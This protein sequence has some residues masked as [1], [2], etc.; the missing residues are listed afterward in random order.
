[1]TYIASLSFFGFVM[2]PESI[3]I[4]PNHILAI[5]EWPAFPVYM[6]FRYCLGL[7]TFTID[8]LMDLYVLY[9]S[10]WFFSEK[11]NNSTRLTKYNLHLMNSSMTS[12]LLL[13]SNMLILI[14]LSGYYWCLRICNIWHCKP[15]PWSLLASSYLLFSHNCISL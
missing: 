5:T 7:L 6:I 15:A 4:D 14:F 12:H 8:L 13:F 11:I 1:M 2:L 9:P 3:S 10:S